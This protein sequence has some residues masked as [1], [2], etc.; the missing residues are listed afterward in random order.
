MFIY[1]PT[2]IDIYVTIFICIYT[3]A[4]TYVVYVVWS[5]K[6]NH[7]GFKSSDGHSGCSSKDFSRAHNRLSGTAAEKL[8]SNCDP[9][10]LSYNHITLYDMILYHI[11]L[12]DISR[13]SV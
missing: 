13:P 10:V 2:P 8:K 12:H 1:I 5:L 9:N 11:V 6:K 4:Y 7:K 3:F